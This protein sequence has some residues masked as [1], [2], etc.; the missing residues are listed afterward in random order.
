MSA[1]QKSWSGLGSEAVAW[2]ATTARKAARRKYED[3]AI[4]FTS[5]AFL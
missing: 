5:L 4:L 1:T 3:A 2:E